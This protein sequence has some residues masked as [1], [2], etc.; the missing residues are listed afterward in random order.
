MLIVMTFYMDNMTQNI[1]VLFPLWPFS[2]FIQSSLHITSLYLILLPF[3]KVVVPQIE[4]FLW[5]P[6][7]RTCKNIQCQTRTRIFSRF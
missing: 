7:Q 5:I 6:I 2:T 3:I 4:Q 1:S